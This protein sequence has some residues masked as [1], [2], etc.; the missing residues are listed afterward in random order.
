[1]ENEKEINR[2][3]SSDYDGST[4]IIEPSKESIFKKILKVFGYG[5]LI[6]GGGILLILFNILQFLV[7]AVVGLGMI[8]WAITE[9]LK[10]SII[11]GLLVLLIGTPL[12]IALAHWA[13]WFLL[14]FAVFSVI[15]WG[16]AHLFAL[17]IS[18]GNAWDIV[19]FIIKML[20]LGGMAFIGI[21][22]F[23]E[24]IKEKRIL[25]FSKEY[26]WGVLLFCFL[27]WLF[28]L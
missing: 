14:V 16:I 4:P 21:T 11:I 19:W 13:F 25:G 8:G 9:F 23:I 10:G 12:A 6:A 2:E 3:F 18:F 20:I 22:G 1:M 7:T 5:S 24:A 27:F 15:I 28:F 26:W 17:N